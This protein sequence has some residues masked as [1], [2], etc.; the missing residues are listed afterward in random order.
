MAE[1]NRSQIIGI[2]CDAHDCPRRHYFHTLLLGT[3]ID[4]THPELP[5]LVE[6]GWSL[7]VGQRNRRTY[8]PD[9]GPKAEMRRLW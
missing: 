7:W 1:L 9:H 5:A 3:F 8:C 2:S 6:E 4:T